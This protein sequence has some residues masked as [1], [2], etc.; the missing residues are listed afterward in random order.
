MTVRPSLILI[1]LIAVLACSGKASLTLAAEKETKDGKKDG[2]VD[3][4]RDNNLSLDWKTDGNWSI[5]DNVATLTPR[6]GEKGW[7]RWSSYL[8]SKKEFKDFEITFDY[9]LQK[10]SNSGFYFRVADKNDPV[11]KGKR[12]GRE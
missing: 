11:A 1:C 7:S 10:G 6:E 5:K 8:W 2:W 9:L 12:H 3:L 4:L